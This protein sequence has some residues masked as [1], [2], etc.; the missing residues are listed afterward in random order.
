MGWA[1][2]RQ[3]SSA[4]LAFASLHFSRFCNFQL[5]VNV[6]PKLIELQSSSCAHM[7]EREIFFLNVTKKIKIGL[8]AGH[9]RA[10]KNSY[11]FSL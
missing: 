6:V 11:S 7:K 9:Q 10:D 1:S 8:W 2:A 4:S 5:Q 3:P